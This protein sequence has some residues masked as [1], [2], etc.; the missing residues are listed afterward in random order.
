MPEKATLWTYIRGGPER[1][2]AAMEIKD[3]L[4]IS[5]KAVESRERTAETSRAPERSTTTSGTQAQVA[6]TDR[7][8]LSPRSKEMAKAAEALART[9]EVRQQKVEELKAAVADGT[10]QVDEREVAQKMIL[11]ML[12][13]V[14]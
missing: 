12:E 7:V 9:P 11:N 14:V 4:G 13:D 1:G 10:Y 5:N 6:A 3:A 8:E 2:T